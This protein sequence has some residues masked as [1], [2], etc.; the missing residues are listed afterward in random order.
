MVIQYIS[1]PLAEWLIQWPATGGS[2][3]ERL[4]ITL[5]RV[6]EALRELSTQVNQLL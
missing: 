5:R 1:A 3:Y 4:Q 2:A 6:P